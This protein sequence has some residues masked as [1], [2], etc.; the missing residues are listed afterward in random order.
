MGLPTTYPS[1]TRRRSIPSARSR[2]RSSWFSARRRARRSSPGWSSSYEMRV[3]TSLPPKRCG[4]S[5][6]ATP[7]VVPAARSTISSTT[8]V[9]PTSIATP[10]GAPSASP[11]SVPSS[12]TTRPPA[13]VTAGS[14]SPAAASGASRIRSLRR[15]TVNS[16]SPS[17]R[18]TRAWQAS[19]N[20]APRS[21]S[22]SVLADSWSPPCRTSTTHSRQR[23]V[24]RHDA[25][26]WAASSAA[27]SNRRWPATSGRRSEPWMTSGITHQSPAP[28]PTTGWSVGPFAGDLPPYRGP[29][30][31]RDAGPRTDSLA[32]R[33]W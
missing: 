18:S 17:T 13:T 8:V 23:P 12:A 5:S 30:R 7:S 9:V 19:R 21:A 2:S 31:A 25:G 11:R 10:S 3:M 6:A 20:P 29:V 33:P 15:R 1:T 27:S 22:A 26:T 28:S 14:T 24:R 32:R 4:F 16:R